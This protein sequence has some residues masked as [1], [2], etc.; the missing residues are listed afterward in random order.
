MAKKAEELRPSSWTTTHTPLPGTK[1]EKSW[2][3][4]E[5]GRTL[6]PNASGH[7]GIHKKFKYSANM[8]APFFNVHF[9]E[10]LLPIMLTRICES[11][12]V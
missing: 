10:N 2:Q 11:V 5:R 4:Y 6:V 7:V 1:E 9:L 3:N 12:D 8:Y